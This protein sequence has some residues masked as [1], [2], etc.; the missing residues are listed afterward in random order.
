MSKHRA[1]RF[2]ACC[3]VLFL[4]AWTPAAE[5]E[6]TGGITL[7]VSFE[8]DGPDG[9]QPVPIDAPGAQQHYCD[10]IRRF[11]EEL[12]Q[13]TEGAQWIKRVRFFEELGEPHDVTWNYRIPGEFVDS[14]GSYLEYLR[15][16]ETGKAGPDYYD[17]PA[18]SARSLGQLLDHEFGHY[19]Y[20]LPDEYVNFYDYRGG[21]TGICPSTYM[22]IDDKATGTVCDEE[23]ATCTDEPC[24]LQ[25]QCMEPQ[26]RWNQ[27]CAWDYLNDD[28]QE[29]ACSKKA[30]N[31]G[32]ACDVDDDCPPN[33]GAIKDRGVCERGCGSA[34]ICL[35]MNSM[36]TDKI[37][38]DKPG[39]GTVRICKGETNV[40]IARGNTI[41][42]VCLMR[43]AGSGRR[44]CDGGRVGNGQVA[45]ATHEY[46]SPPDSTYQGPGLLDVDLGNTVGP[47]VPE[48]TTKDGLV[49]DFLDH[50]CWDRA[51]SRQ[52]D[53]IGK[54]APGDLYT[55]FADPM[56][57]VMLPEYHCDWLIDFL[58]TSPHVALLVD[59]SGSMSYPDTSNP[60][61]NALESAIDGALY[62]YNRIV[63]VGS[64]GGIYYFDNGVQPAVSDGSM[65][66]FAQKTAEIDDLNDPGAAGGTNIAAVLRRGID[67]ILDSDAPLAKRNLVLFSDGKQNDNGDD[68]YAEAQRACDNGMFVW[69]IA[70]GNADSAALDELSKCG[71][72]TISGTESA[73]DA[74]FG[75]PDPLEIK[76][77]LARVGHRIAGD[78]E[79]LE[80]RAFLEGLAAGVIETREFV[81][82]E[83]SDAVTFSWLA[84]RTCVQ[85]DATPSSCTAVLNLLTNVELEDP[86]GARFTVGRSTADERGVYRSL[87]IEDPE[88]GTWI[89]RIDKSEP[90]PP[91]FFPGEWDMRVPETRVSWVAHVAAPR[92]EADAWVLEPRQPLDAPVRIR[93]ALS[94]GARL[95]RLSVE[96]R[97]THA[98]E[99]WSV[100]MSDDGLHHD[101][102]ALDGIYG[103]IFNPDGE[104]TNV[105]AGGYR[106]KVRMEAIPGQTLLRPPGEESGEPQGDDV[107]PAL[108]DPGHVVAEAETSFR[109]STRYTRDP[110]GRPNPGSLALSCPDLV[111]GQT[112]AGIPVD[113]TGVAIDLRT[114][115]IT[116]G[117]SGVETTLET[118]DCTSCADTATDPGGSLTFSAVVG[119]DADTGPRTFYLQEQSDILRSIDACRVCSVPG[120]EA[121][122]GRDDDC[123]GL[124]DEDTTGATDSDRDGVL[125]VCDNCPFLANRGQ[126]DLDGDGEGDRC[127]TSDGVITVAFDSGI[128]LDW[129]EE[130]GSI[131]WNVYRGDLH[132]LVDTGVY[133]QSPGSTANSDRFCGLAVSSLDDLHTPP[134]GTCAY[135]LVTED[136]PAA[137]EGSL[138]DDSSGAERPN[139][140]PCPTGPP[141]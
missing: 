21:G 70:Y 121:C 69:T 25:R 26:A 113:V 94:D 136:S 128:A 141:V 47:P 99:T 86:M 106:V 91:P 17:P 36:R 42:R 6:N 46:T 16:R 45:G 59:K 126:A 130:G 135:Y 114:T 43:G 82:P 74:L 3:C 13:T 18:R 49:D 48:I 87:R 53:L 9:T 28:G 92:I 120:D 66:E 107:A 90:N 61:R 5:V 24:V 139:D 119:P 122:N 123:N 140:N 8:H 117:R 102:D 85:M 72:F 80:E 111:R 62:F 32:D 58:P 78:V 64:Y 30:D 51:A 76:T 7:V 96:A 40:S 57:N 108:V 132:T 10:T 100:R 31:A 68:P 20:Q 11:S 77:A 44:W 71:P 104:L 88:P 14:Y 84:N 4:H 98:G 55:D 118:V 1:V 54:H 115:R 93:A 131:E 95:S 101:G 79:V 56:G 67:D 35:G 109:L 63:P 129:D 23:A 27:T 2:A 97:V 105:T 103:G 60:P 34:G 127:D 52:I 73:G 75:E 110:E 138:G 116:L 83:S 65:L 37:G 125:Q 133:T 39:D 112:Y 81:V 89:A 12:Y 38:T 124:I 41:D 134:A 33:D 19:F 29:T 137:G 15:I 50:S 22:A